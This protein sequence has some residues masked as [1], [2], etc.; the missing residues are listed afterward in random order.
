MF[1]TLTEGDIEDLVARYACQQVRIALH[2]ILP[3][4]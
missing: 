2:V 4:M 1:D 3:S